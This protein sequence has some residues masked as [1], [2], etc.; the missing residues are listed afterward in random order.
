M[1]T[2]VRGGAPADNSTPET[3]SMPLISGCKVNGGG[4]GVEASTR[5][6]VQ[7]K[8]LTVFCVVAYAVGN[9]AAE[10]LQRIGCHTRVLACLVRLDAFLCQL[11]DGLA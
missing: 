6:K 3:Q 9:P 7:K 11:A 8:S 1:V 10:G 4:G 5:K 2:R